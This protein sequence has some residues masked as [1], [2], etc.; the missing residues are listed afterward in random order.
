MKKFLFGGVVSLSMLAVGC[1]GTPPE[2]PGVTGV[3]VDVNG[4]NA[5]NSTNA[6]FGFFELN[7]LGSFNN[8]DLD[9]D[10]NLDVDEDANLNGVLDD[11]ED[12]DGDGNLDSDEDANGNGV[13]DRE[14]LD[15][16]GDG[17]VDGGDTVSGAALFV[18]TSE[19]DTLCADL[20]T[21]G[22]EPTNDANT[23]V[24]AF[25]FK[26]GAAQT[27]L[28]TGGSFSNV[29][30]AGSFDF[31]SVQGSFSVFADSVQTVNA[32]SSAD[33]Q[34]DNSV[35]EVVSLGNTLTANYSGTLLFD[36]ITQAAINSPME[37]TFVDVARCG[38][39]DD[40]ASLIVGLIAGFGGLEEI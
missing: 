34:D 33:D 25:Q 38:N 31:T 1:G 30:G 18:L 37:G 22:F 35:F 32:T 13:L 11:G 29:E 7:G 2:E 19:T 10:G 40:L 6:V 21:E 24:F 39:A 27:D 4:A 8:E 36:E 26:T 5:D 9:R 16:N 23:S 28:A 12:L 14:Q 3:V 20:A 17:V 15:L